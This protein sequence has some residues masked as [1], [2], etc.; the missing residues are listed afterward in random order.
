MS[1]P[2]HASQAATLLLLAALCLSTSG[3]THFTSAA[4]TRQTTPAA[5]SSIIFA[6]ERYADGQEIIDPLVIVRGGRFSEPPG[7][8]GN[9]GT[10]QG[11]RAEAEFVKEFYRP[12][13]EYR[14]LFG[15]GEAGTA[16]V[17]EFTE[18]GCVGM[19]AKATLKTTA[20]L[21][22][23]VE[24]LAT[25]SAT[26]GRG[27]GTRRAPTAEERAAAIALAKKIF[28]QKRVPAKA[29]AAM[30]VHNLTAVDTDGDGRQELVG[31]FLV[32]SAY[33]AQYA[34]FLVAKHGAGSQVTLT[35]ALAWFKHG[36]ESDAEYRQLVDVLDID[37]DGVSEIFIRSIYYESHDYSVYKRTA[38]TWRVVYTGGGGGC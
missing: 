35:P 28:G 34:L 26:Y 7:G 25:D 31:S 38:G 2:R 22:G 3:P 36:R 15:G 29:A 18:P 1:I 23:P 24:A 30:E 16:R 9:D 13:R 8:M 27:T 5:S 19:V 12:G 11:Q 20:R 37:G 33:G 10:P 4:Q 21:G 14:V 17:V 32:M 6:V